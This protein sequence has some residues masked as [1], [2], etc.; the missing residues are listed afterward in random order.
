ME[1]KIQDL[2]LD[3]ISILCQK[4][5]NIDQTNQRTITMVAVVTEISRTDNCIWLK[6][7]RSLPMMSKI[8]R[9]S[10]FDLLSHSDS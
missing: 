9:T 8:I 7:T 3:P 6:K 5:S 1:I 10:K 4:K 2:D